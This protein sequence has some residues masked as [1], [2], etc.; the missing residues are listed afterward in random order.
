MENIKEL[1]ILLDFGCWVSLA[2]LVDERD[3]RKAEGDPA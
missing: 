2:S 1:L 3:K